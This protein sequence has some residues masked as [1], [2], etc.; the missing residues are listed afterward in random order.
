MLVIGRP[1]CRLTCAKSTISNNPQTAVCFLPPS[2][3]RRIF[4]RL[5]FFCCIEKNGCG[6]KR[7]CMRESLFVSKNSRRN[8]VEMMRNE[9]KMIMNE[10]V[11][12]WMWDSS[13]G[14][15]MINDPR[16]VSRCVRL[17]GRVGMVDAGSQATLTD[18]FV[19]PQGQPHRR[20]PF[21]DAS[22]EM[23]RKGIVWHSWRAH[24]EGVQKKPLSNHNGLD[25][26]RVCRTDAIVCALASLSRRALPPSILRCEVDRYLNGRQT[27]ILSRTKKRFLAG[28]ENALISILQL[29]QKNIAFLSAAELA[30]NRF[31]GW[32]WKNIEKPTLAR[33]SGFGFGWIQTPGFMESGGMVTHGTWM[34]VQF[35]SGNEE[36]SYKA[37]LLDNRINDD[38]YKSWLETC[39]LGLVRQKRNLVMEPK[40]IMAKD[41]KR[42]LQEKTMKEMMRWFKCLQVV[43]GEERM[44]NHPMPCCGFKDV[45]RGSMSLSVLCLRLKSSANSVSPRFVRIP[46]KNQTGIGFSSELLFDQSEKRFASQFTTFLS[47]EDSTQVL[48]PSRNKSRS[49][50]HSST[51]LSPQ[52]THLI[53]TQSLL[54]NFPSHI[55][56]SFLTFLLSIF[57]LSSILSHCSCSCQVRQF[58]LDFFLRFLL[59]LLSHRCS[60]IQILVLPQIIPVSHLYMLSYLRKFVIFSYYLFLMFSLILSFL[61]CF[62]FQSWL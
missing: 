7:M 16:H 30:S 56:N 22:L 19:S 25:V 11:N 49:S 24:Y 55:S 34:G 4:K 5:V 50:T 38:Q 1:R 42:A 51:T 32:A 40:I 12:E 29:Q 61:T 45:E 41:I 33:W 57:L 23:K 58:N 15:G 18:D 27:N 54:V 3:V 36:E 47:H 14:S 44:A 6:M 35:F 62:S 10:S 43:M 2:G 59:T 60:V 28:C 48:N 21:I 46:N 37:T 13:K 8:D 9:G 31:T 20:S 26:L 52:S 17:L 39:R 53:T